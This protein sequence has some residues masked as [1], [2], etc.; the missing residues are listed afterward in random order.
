MTQANTAMRR[1]R[2]ITI[3][4][5]AAGLPLLYPGSRPAAATPLQIW[6]G[7]ALGADAMLQIQHPDPHQADRLI[8][9]SLREVARLER[10]F[11]LYQ[12]D[13][14]L[15]R[16]NRAGRLDDPPADLLRLLAQ[17]ARFS[18]LT[19]GA[20]DPTVQPLW[21]VYAEHFSRPDADPTGPPHA[22]I[23]AALQRVG[24]RYIELSARHIRFGLPGMA[25][26]LNGIAQGYITDRVVELLRNA[27]MQHA[28]VD[29]GETRAIGGHPSGGAWRVGLQQPGERRKIG[30]RIALQDQAVATS[31]GYGTLLDPAGRFNHIFDPHTGGSSWRYRSVSVVAPDAT[32]ADALSTAFSLMPLPRA[33]EVARKLK[34]QA[35]FVLDDGRWVQPTVTT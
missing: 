5:A 30:Q 17:S 12:P 19:S 31:G 35:W 8:A 22:A 18:Q 24:Y 32:T 9:D 34:L 14:A 28:L 3:A 16:L 29:M 10:V 6:T 13:S 11:S 27:G 1:R 2:F 4:A 23:A 21:D 15:V 7:A 33:V 20:F 25:L 26:T